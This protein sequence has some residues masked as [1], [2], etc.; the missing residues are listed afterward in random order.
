MMGRFVIAVLVLSQRLGAVTQL[1][2]GLSQEPVVI[3]Y[4]TMLSLSLAY[5]GSF[6]TPSRAIAK[7]LSLGFLVVAAALL[8]ILWIFLAKV[9]KNLYVVKLK[10]GFVLSLKFGVLPLVVGCL[11]DFC[12]LP[13]FGTKVSWRLELVSDFPF[14]MI[15]HWL[16]GQLCLLLFF[17]S[18]ELIQKVTQFSLVLLSFVQDLIFY[19]I[20]KRYFFS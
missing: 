10:D 12:I 13:I 17:N 14:V 8:Y 18:M 4:W 7:K 19:E 11:L 6:S 2:S 16:F 3:G 1:L 15:I 20:F 9:W 5:L